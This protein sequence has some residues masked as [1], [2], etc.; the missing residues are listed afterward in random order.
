MGRKKDRAFFICPRWRELAGGDDKLQLARS[1][2]SDPRTI[3]KIASRTPVAYST[4]YGV[5]S[6]LRATRDIKLE[7]ESCIVDK[8]KT[9][10]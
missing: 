8:R 7:P 6:V 3:D 10:A 2:R 4:L 1:L 5:L 9:G